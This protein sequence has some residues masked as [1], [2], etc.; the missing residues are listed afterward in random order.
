[1]TRVRVRSV[2]VAPVLLGL[3]AFATLVPGTAPA[4]HPA[5]GALPIIHASDLE[6][7]SLAAL[8]RR[9][10]LEATG[11]QGD[12]L[13]VA[14]GGALDLAGAAALAGP[15][16]SVD[17][18]E[19]ASFDVVNLAHRDLQG[20][21]SDLAGAL[22]RSR[23]R[24]VSASFRL[25]PPAETPWKGF[26]VVERDGTRTAFVGV[27]E[28]SPALELP[29]GRVL[30]GLEFLEPR[31]A[32]EH[33]VKQAS[34]EAS[35]VV[36]LADG[37]LAG[38]GKLLLEIPGIDLAIISARSGAAP[39]EGIGGRLWVAPTGGGA[40][41]VLVV[42][43][44]DEGA[45]RG[46]G[47][48]KEG[49]SG[50]EWASRVVALGRPAVPSPLLADVLARHGLDLAR[51]DLERATGAAPGATAPVG[52]ARAIERGKLVGVGASARNRATEVEVRSIGI[53]D[54]FGGIEAPEG[55]ALLV[56]HTRW[57]NILPPREVRD[58]QVPV[59][60]LIPKISD[61][62]YCVADG[63]TNLPH[64]GTWSGGE[65]SGGNDPAAAEAFAEGRVELPAPGSVVE[66]WILH[67]I[68]AEADP[69]RLD[70]HVLDSA[71]G[72]T[73]LPLLVAPGG[74]D[75]AR[76]SPILPPLRNE[77]LEAG[78]FAVRRE[79]PPAGPEIPGRSELRQG[80]AIREDGEIQD[81]TKTP[82]GMEV[83][84]IDLL[85]RSVLTFPGDATAYDPAAKPGQTI[86][87]GT[88][89][90]WGE[91]HDHIRILV[92]GESA[93]AP[94]A[95]SAL[96]ESPRFLPGVWT[97]GALV[98]RVP[99]GRT[100]LE[101]L[102]EFPNASIPGRDG[103]V[104]PGSLLFPIE[105]KRPAPSARPA[106]ASVAD[107][108]F[109]ASILAASAA[110]RFAGVAAEGGERFLVVDVRLE[111]GGKDAEIFQ[112]FEQ[113]RH[114]S[115]AGD[116][117]GADPLC[118]DGPRPPTERLRVPA[119]ERRSFQLAYRI[120]RGE[121]RP[122]IGFAGWTL[123]KVLDLPPLVPAPVAEVA[124]SSHGA[125]PPDGPE[126]PDGAETTDV[127]ESPDVPETTDVEEVAEAAAGAQVME[128]E[129]AEGAEPA[130]GLPEPPGGLPEPGAI[131]REPRGLAGVGLTPEDVNRAIDRGSAFLWSLIREEDLG[132]SKQ[133]LGYQDEHY[134]AALALVHS[135]AHERFPDF[136]A[137]L[138]GFLQ[139]YDP[140]QEQIY[141]AG[142]ICMTVEA[143]GDAGLY[144][145]MDRAVRYILDAQ[146]KG[147]S[148]SYRGNAKE[149]PES[150][151][152]LEVLGG[153]PPDGTAREELRRAADWK[154]G[155]DGDNSVSQ[156]ALLGLHAASRC[157]FRIWPEA[158]NR[159]LSVCAKRQN[160]D[161]GW[162]YTTGGSYGSM[163][164]AGVCALAICRHELE[165]PE[166]SRERDSRR[167][168]EW[169]AKRFTVE[170]NP[171]SGDWHYYYLYS[172]E[173]TGRLLDTEFI[174]E[175]E[176]YPIGARWLIDHQGSDGGWVG[177][178]SET[179]PR[180]ATSF[181]LLFLT[182][183]TP[184]LRAER[185]EGDGM[186]RTGVDLGPSCRYYF[187]LDASGSMLEPLDGRQKMDVARD[188][189]A[190]IVAE[191][192]PSAEVALRVYGHRRRASEQGADEDTAL[193]VPLR[194]LDRAAFLAK[195]RAVRA[196]GKTPLARSLLE[197]RD[198]LSRASRKEPVKVVLLTDGGE[199]TRPRGD[200]VAAAG[201]LGKVEGIEL[202]V[203]GFDIGRDDW[204][205][206][207]RA[208]VERSGGRYWAAGD[209]LSLEQLVRS[210]VLG[211][212]R[213]FALLDAGGREVRS[214]RF[215]ATMALTP[216]KYRLRTE[217]AGSPYE[218]ELW[219]NAGEATSVVF[220]AARI[221][222]G[223]ATRGARERTDD[224][225]GAAA[226]TG[227]APQPGGKEP[228][229]GTG[230]ERKAAPKFCTQ[231][232]GSLRPDSRFC[233]SC[234]A[235]VKG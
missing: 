40:V 62:V 193:E 74:P 182:R 159:A 5:T 200:P 89:A 137:A 189:V 2:P 87:V 194:R 1:M 192:P 101:L 164:A 16:A 100:S 158:W 134:P 217:F 15:D 3:A 174:G 81:G 43:G 226:E 83:L 140:L 12:A 10:I 205:A 118:L 111:N 147:G 110:D 97:G 160:G 142:V 9:G 17:L 115:E 152:V 84:A 123:A 95:R 50:T 104:Q 23:V 221:S 35:R 124:E 75:P 127:P 114:I 107:G 105:G 90:D 197:A 73:A 215:G 153:L 70:L 119:G 144:G 214:G 77:V 225:A 57:R 32:L 120:A 232:G 72:S 88:V 231:C 129:G 44:T 234:G 59:A 76:L 168:H 138:R 220:H 227:A 11:L 27:A 69:V 63:T 71:H 36:V 46:A 48:G 233:T 203:I 58:R 103:V 117:E 169:L 126:P 186:L 91:A 206:E 230:P 167:G 68:E 125:E 66:G 209:A 56:L 136:D 223:S 150:S 229:T 201:E 179:D 166:P 156:F 188:A 128:S 67:A 94:L 133:D 31:R 181:A 64:V 47:A 190:A 212:P 80:G 131:R 218:E 161:G 121:T 86:Q 196:R 204:K 235:Q 14:T 228:P 53:L 143:Y 24:F 6:A 82:E 92:D 198:D 33:A 207:L 108:K 199:D 210:A 21:A 185:K 176:W 93:L 180:L 154:L 28:R 65:G 222:T 162:G 191:L 79:E 113:L 13:L 141:N 20:A 30:E 25:R 187:I 157:G 18:L 34:T 8:G 39:A 148:W 146:G 151:R 135:E 149:I 184:T 61:H 41:G 145:A 37:S 38:L 99:R 7:L 139:R 116:E 208:M 52:V 172:L 98:F 178:G 132:R 54:R 109:R 51:V 155:V 183:A 165:A 211:I 45:P 96:A 49:A 29:G 4:Q 106:I 163:T 171:E 42:R 177:E 19:V 60:Y 173:R 202:H 26:A 170:K 219:I 224:D 22:K 112:P 195:L 85:A 102:C 55:G 213:S 122:R 216:G 175:N 78:V 130:D